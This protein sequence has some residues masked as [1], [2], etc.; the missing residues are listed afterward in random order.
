MNLAERRHF[1]AEGY[2]VLREVFGAEQVV[3]LRDAIISL[4]KKLSRS[5]RSHD[6]GFDPWY[7]E[8]GHGDPIN[9]NRVIYLNDLHLRQPRLDAHM[10]S[11]ELASIFCSIWDADLRSFQ[12]AAVIKPKQDNGEWRGWHQDMPDYEPLSNDRNACAIV[13]LDHMGPDTGGTSLVPRSHR[14]GLPERTLTPVAGWPRKLKRRSIAGFDES[15]AN[16]VAPQFGPGDALIFHSCLYHKANNNR[17]DVSK[18]GLINVY[19]AEDCIDIERR[20]TFKAANIPI[21][22]D[23]VPIA[24]SEAAVK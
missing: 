4:T 21:T 23:R 15:T 17:D 7:A 11:H 20:N 16:V 5:D 24:A 10:R 12:A 1:E 6:T 3:E 14:S 13:Y 18:I 19:Q 2:V 8:D 9:P 22:R